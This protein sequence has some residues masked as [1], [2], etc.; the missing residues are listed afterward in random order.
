MGGD[1]SQHRFQELICVLCMLPLL[2]SVPGAVAL[3]VQVNR[4]SIVDPGKATM[5][6]RDRHGK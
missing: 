2:P 4:I 6:D 5:S 3:R 1:K